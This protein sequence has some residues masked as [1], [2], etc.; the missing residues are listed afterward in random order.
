M[1]HYV[2]LWEEVHKYILKMIIVLDIMMFE[3]WF[4]YHSVLKQFV[5]VISVLI[6]LNLRNFDFL[7]VS[8]G[9]LVAL[10]ILGDIIQVF[11][12]FR[13]ISW[14]NKE[15][16][17]VFQFLQSFQMKIVGQFWSTANHHSVQNSSSPSLIIHDN[18]IYCPQRR[19]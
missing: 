2:W 11:T 3:S 16:K 18:G 1:H 12:T 13:N 7:F 15:P 14:R 8:E 4:C 6:Q 17:Q 10:K 9:T 19:I 5:S